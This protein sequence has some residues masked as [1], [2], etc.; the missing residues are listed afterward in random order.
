MGCLF[1][2]ALILLVIIVVLIN[3]PS[4]TE[5]A[6]K[7]GIDNYINQIFNPERSPAAFPAITIKPLLP[8]ST[9]IVAIEPENTPVP[10]METEREPEPTKEI[11]ATPAPENKVVEQT[12]KLKLRNS[13]VYF[14]QVD[15]NGGIAIVNVRRPVHFEDA[16]LKNTMEVLLDGPNTD[17]S[18]KGIRSL[19]P[20]ETKLR[21]IYV[22]G[23]TAYLDFNE[24]F[25][26]NSLGKEGMD[27]Q[28]KQIVYSTLEFQNIAQVQILI[29][30]EKV[31]YLGPEG[32]N[33]DK[34]LSRNSFIN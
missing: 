3:V 27:A 8:D 21:N 31:K 10:A 34:P 20:K 12:N 26:F 13:R 15:A 25:R 11:T 5:V 7:T 28:L 2:L 22:K 32:I 19:I 4:I 23:D 6:R 33:I 1:W 18:N 17:E 16:P 9:P 14:V 24:N 30:G 29:N